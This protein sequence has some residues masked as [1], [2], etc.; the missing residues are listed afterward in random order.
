MD[1]DEPDWELIRDSP[2]LPTGPPTPEQVERMKQIAREQGW[3]TDE[4]FDFSRR[5]GAR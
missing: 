1:D 3:L 5:P 4:G 2:Y